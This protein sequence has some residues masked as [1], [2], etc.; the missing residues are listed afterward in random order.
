MDII[1]KKLINLPYLILD[2]AMATELERKGADIND[3]LW[4]AKTLLEQ[5]DL[6]YSTHLDYLKAGADIICTCTYQA[7]FQGFEERGLSLQKSKSIFK[8][9]VDLARRAKH[10]YL[11]N[12]AQ[13]GSPLIAGSIGSYGAFLADGS[14]Y[15]GN[16][17]IEKNG[18]KDFHRFRMEWLMECGID[19]FIFE[20]IPSIIEAQA[21]IELLDE[22]SNLTALFSF[23]CKNKMQIS[24]G[25]LLYEAA[26]LVS[27]SKWI[28]SIGMNCLNPLWVGSLLNEMESIRKPLLAYPNDGR[29]WDGQKKCWLS[30]KTTIDLEQLWSGWIKKGVKIIGG[31]CNT[32]PFHIEQLVDFRKRMIA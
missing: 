21:I 16:Y 29:F 5:P 25:H 13:A 6:V 24:D 14:E 32:S 31:C 22:M 9:S 17:K 1:K 10:E 12:T 20:T 3:P 27:D 28:I 7:T 11:N 18:L 4:S 26:S 2:G 8:H 23:S 19:V 30:S 15:T